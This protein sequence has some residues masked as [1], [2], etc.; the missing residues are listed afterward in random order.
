MVRATAVIAPRGLP[1]V[2]VDDIGAFENVADAHVDTF[3]VGG[4]AQS[5]QILRDE[6]GPFML[7][8]ETTNEGSPLICGRRGA[9]SSVRS[10]LPGAAG[11]HWADFAGA[12]TL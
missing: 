9:A 2:K 4:P 10:T 11:W 5:A 3:A 8:G 1:L 12:Q 6:L 7:F